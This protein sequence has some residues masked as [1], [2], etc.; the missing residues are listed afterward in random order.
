MP[1]NVS[2]SQ[3]K[4]E[5]RAAN[6]AAKAQGQEDLAKEKAEKQRLLKNEDKLSSLKK[7][8]ERLENNR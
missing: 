2:E 7:R 8:Q 6:L 3:R 1:R 5:T 4:G